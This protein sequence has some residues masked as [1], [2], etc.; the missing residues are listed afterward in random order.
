MPKQEGLPEENIPEA[1]IAPDDSSVELGLDK[2]KNIKEGEDRKVILE[3]AER[4]QRELEG[5]EKQEAQNP[6]IIDELEKSIE[7]QGDFTLSEEFKKSKLYELWQEPRIREIY[8]NQYLEKIKK[9]EIGWSQQQEQALKLGLP[10]GGDYDSSD[11]W[12]AERARDLGLSVTTNRKEV[13][14][15]ESAR[16]LELPDDATKQEIHEEQT[17]ANGG[18]DGAYYWLKTVFTGSRADRKARRTGEM[19]QDL[20][21]QEDAR[22]AETENRTRKGYNEY[23]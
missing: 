22:R 14:R 6:E 21:N 23:H 18:V 11:I 17:I 13:A 10:E 8:G 19:L 12:D 16:R 1:T 7:G 2:S 4:K 9:L 20:A 5:A 3:Q 15:I